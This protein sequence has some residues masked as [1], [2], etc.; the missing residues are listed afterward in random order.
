M[1]RG[2][3]RTGMNVV[4]GRPNG[5][6]TVGEVVKVHETTAE[7]RALET[8]GD[9]NRGSEEHRT[10]KQPAG[11]VWRPTFDIMEHLDGS[12]LEALRTLPPKDENL[13]DYLER[14]SETLV[15]K[16]QSEEEIAI[17]RAIFLVYKERRSISS[18]ISKYRAKRTQDAE[19]EADSLEYLRDKQNRRLNHLFQA[20]GRPASLAAICAWEDERRIRSEID[21]ESSTKEDR[22]KLLG[23]WATI[24]RDFDDL[25]H[26]ERVVAW[27]KSMNRTETV[28]GCAAEFTPPIP[29]KFNPPKLRPLDLSRFPTL[30]QRR[31]VWQ[32]Q[33]ETPQPAHTP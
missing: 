20:L 27:N 16:F 32:E 6:K 18:L 12:L 8:R 22:A 26:G 19:M 33:K 15:L 3:C 29:A 9:G 25:H 4:F 23:R 7:V 11:T 21:K 31:K 13:L 10:K 1:L 14:G 17:L 24:C 30:K 5:E 28:K 2:L